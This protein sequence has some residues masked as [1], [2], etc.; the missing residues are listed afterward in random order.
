MQ[1]K[2]PLATL[3]LIACTTQMAMAQD[4]TQALYALPSERIMCKVMEPT[5]A[6][7]ADV[8]LTF[9]DPTPF[10]RETIV[11]FTN[12]GRPL[13]MVIL[14]TERKSEESVSH[15]L[16]IR[17]SGT[18]LYMRLRLEN[19]SGS[20]PPG[21]VPLTTEYL[22]PLDVTNAEKLARVLWTR[23]CKPHAAS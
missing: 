6:D 14:L 9:L 16:A 17:F 22:T 4:A 12:V 21:A 19:E 5:K 18:G 20:G 15:R 3:C 23:R 11:A 2:I 1:L 7:S 10:P 8:L 13:Y